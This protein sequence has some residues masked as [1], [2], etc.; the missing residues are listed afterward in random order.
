MYDFKNAF[1]YIFKEKNWPLKVGI[2]TTMM[3]IYQII[4]V[5]AEVIG[6]TPRYS[7]FYGT[8]TEQY[9]ELGLVVLCLAVPYFL[10]WIM[11]SYWYSYEIIQATLVSTETK[12]IFKEAPMTVVKKAGKLL[13]VDFLL[14]V[15]FLCLWLILLILNVVG[16][17]LT[18]ENGA[19]IVLE[20][21]IAIVSFVIT[22]ISFVVFMLT[23]YSSYLRLLA[24]NTFGEGIKYV[25]NF[26]FGWKNKYDFGGLFIISILLSIVVGFIAWVPQIVVE[27]LVNKGDVKEILIFLV[28]LPGTIASVYVGTFVLDR[29]TAEVYKN[30]VTK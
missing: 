9:N 18:V 29:I 2:I 7:S 24:T 14:S 13:L 4:M 21:I 23:Y 28:T 19:F 5:F 25:E 3:I 12:L 10:I 17:V 8:T 16:I 11:V 22:L 1:S 26:K 20:I 6:K 27:L 30:I 15:P